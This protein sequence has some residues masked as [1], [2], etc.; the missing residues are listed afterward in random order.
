MENERKTM[1]KKKRTINSF[2]DKMVNPKKQRKDKVM[3]KD[4]TGAN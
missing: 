2:F 4:G 1:E 3:T